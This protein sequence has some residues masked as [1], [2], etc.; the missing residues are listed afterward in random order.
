MGR[1]VG[2]AVLGGAAGRCVSVGAML[3]RA[4]SRRNQDT[5]GVMLT[6]LAAQPICTKIGR[7]S[8]GP[9]GGSGL[10]QYVVVM[11]RQRD[12]VRRN[13]VCLS[14]LC[15]SVQIAGATRTEVASC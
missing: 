11:G 2:T 1:C 12:V 3:K 7:N 6:T 9:G 4:D 10:L 13:D 5:S 8:A 14:E 15:R